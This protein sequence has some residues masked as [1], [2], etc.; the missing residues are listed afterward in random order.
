MTD[1]LSKLDVSGRGWNTWASE[2]PAQIQHL[3]RS[4]TLTPCIYAASKNAFTDFPA[5]AG[6][7]AYGARSVR[8]E[9]IALRLLHAG[10]EIGLRYDRAGDAVRA[11]WS[12]EKLAE[13]GLRVWLCFA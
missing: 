12:T 13:W 8:G 11:R 1:W 9:Q 5:Q 10:S 6:G 4:L 2:W 3:P 7:V